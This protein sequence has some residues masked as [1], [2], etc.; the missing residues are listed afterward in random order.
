MYCSRKQATIFCKQ[1]K[2]FTKDLW[3]INTI[4]W[5]VIDFLQKPGQKVRPFPPSVQPSPESNDP[6]GAGG[7]PQKRSNFRDNKF[8][9][10]HLLKHASGAKEG[11]RTKTSDQFKMLEQDPLLQNGGP[12]HGK[13]L[14]PKNIY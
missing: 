2:L 14:P 10:R 11:W 1:W 4:Q 5:Y 7:I 13:E 12:S 3:V 9:P 8:P 6:R